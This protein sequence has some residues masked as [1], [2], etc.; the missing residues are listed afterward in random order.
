ML[1]LTG[2]RIWAAVVA[3]LAGAASADTVVYVDANATGP[4]YDGLTWCTA[5][6]DLHVALGGAAADTEIRV[7]DGVYLPD[8]AGLP[9]P[10]TATFQLVNG[11]TVNGGFAGCGAPN[12]DLR[13]PT[14]Y[15]TVLSGDLNGDDGTGGGNSDNTYHVVTTGGTD[16][17]AWLDGVTITAGNAS[18]P[19]E[20]SH[21]RGGGVFNDGGSPTLGQCIIT[22][23]EVTFNGGG[24]YNASG[25][26]PLLSGCTF[27]GNYSGQDGGGMCNIASSPEL[28]DGV[29]EG[30]W[31][32][33]LSG[34]GG[35]VASGG[36]APTFTDCTFRTNRGRIGGAMINYG[37]APTLTGCDFI[38]NTAEQSGGGMYNNDHSDAFLTDCL[39]DGNSA[40]GAGGGMRN[41]DS[42]PVLE[43]CTFDGNEAE[44]LGG[45]MA[46]TGGSPVLTDCRFIRNWTIS[47][48]L[49]AIGGGM[50]NAGGAA[51]DMTDCLFL[52]NFATNHGGAIYNDDATDLE[53]IN[54]LFLGNE[55]EH[56]GAAIYSF[57]STLALTNVLFSGNTGGGDGGAAFNDLTTV[58][59]AN[60]TVSGNHAGSQGGGIYDY[61]GCGVT[62]VNSIFW[63]NTDGSGG[64]ETAQVF[65]NP[66]NFLEVDYSCVEG[67]TGGF[68]GTGNH[69]DDPQFVD[70]DGPDNVIGTQDDN[71]RLPADSTCVDVGDNAAVTVATDL[72]GNPRVV[73][74]IVDMGSYEYRSPAV[75]ATSAWTLLVMLLVLLI[76][77]TVVFDRNRR[78]AG[79]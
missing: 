49:D 38:E 58:T 68:G 22:D 69:G 39:F 50:H 36:G 23:N 52:Q 24:M 56:D 41:Y 66:S 13:D 18:G 46:N 63:G 55:A 6:P 30:N 48:T 19:S 20:S 1:K 61:V 11:V 15:E 9:D 26:A 37:S 27:T 75:P 42:S 47:D 17:T 2:Q 35:A 44:S 72:D 5:Y 31:C 77:G 29:F 70:A 10:R 67:W 53:L 59:L 65:N 51:P 73:N 62:L 40:T 34:N 3:L 64:G 32:A 57:S 8:P 76:A 71:L 60:C 4:T 33:S 7:A 79:S 16:R 21:D 12:P 74:G 45:G 14:T 28:T 78:G 25:A 54:G 43:D